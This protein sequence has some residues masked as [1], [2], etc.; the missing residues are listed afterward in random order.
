MTLETSRLQDAQDL[1][2]EHTGHD[3]DGDTLGK[4]DRGCRVAQVVPWH[5]GQA[6]VGAHSVPVLTNVRVRPC[7]AHS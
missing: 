4:H 3:L 2:T 6:R 1:T 5:L 7:H